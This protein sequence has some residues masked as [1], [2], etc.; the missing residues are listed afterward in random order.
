MAAWEKR[1]A[2]GVKNAAHKLK[3]SAR[4]VGANALADTCEALEKAGK[5]DDWKTID[6][7]AGVSKDQLAAVETF[8]KAL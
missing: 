4:S 6:A 8:I 1:S 3:S 5:A 2:V 7:L